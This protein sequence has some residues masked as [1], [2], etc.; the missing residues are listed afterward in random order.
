MNIVLKMFLL[1][2]LL[3]QLIL[4]IVTVKKKKLTMKFAS[5][6][7]F[8]ILIMAI[9]V[10]FPNIVFNISELSGFEEPSNMIFLLGFFFLFYMIFILTTSL[11][12]QNEKIKLL[13]QE[14]SMLK[15]RVDKNGKKE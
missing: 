4:I 2:L 5:F 14:V 3:F 9:I 1:L 11:S 12:I 6:W 7:L 10:V 15:K 8:I 13:I